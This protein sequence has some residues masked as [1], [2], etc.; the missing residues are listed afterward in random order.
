MFKAFGCLARNLDGECLTAL[1]SQEHLLL[2]HIHKDYLFKIYD[3]ALSSPY[4]QT[5]RVARN[6][7][8]KQFFHLNQTN[9]ASEYH[10]VLQY[11]ACEITV[12]KEYTTLLRSTL[13][14]SSREF[15]KILIDYIYQF[16]IHS[17]GQNTKQKN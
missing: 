14:I 12:G 11:Y 9:T 13:I 15:N 5:I 17:Q 6:L 16:F 7:L 3:M 8:G 4:E 1:T 2:E 10:L